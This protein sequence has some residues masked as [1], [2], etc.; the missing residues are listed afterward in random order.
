M[1]KDKLD[2][3]YSGLECIKNG[4]AYDECYSCK[5]LLIPS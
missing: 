1:K 5:M 3:V 4:M 2:E